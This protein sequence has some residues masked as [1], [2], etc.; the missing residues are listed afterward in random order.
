MPGAPSTPF[1]AA[2]LVRAIVS[3]PVMLLATALWAAHAEH[4]TAADLALQAMLVLFM[5][6]LLVNVI[7]S[8]VSILRQRH[9]LDASEEPPSFPNCSGARQGWTL[10]ARPSP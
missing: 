6:A 9:V 1:L 3:L 5:A 10:R 7:L 2:A 4:A 8:A